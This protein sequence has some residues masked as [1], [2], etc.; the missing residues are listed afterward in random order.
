MV[1]NVLCRSNG[2]LVGLVWLGACESCPV[3]LAPGD[4]DD[5]TQPRNRKPPLS[6]FLAWSLN[7]LSRWNMTSPPGVPGVFDRSNVHFL[8]VKRDR[9]K[10]PY[11]HPSNICHGPLAETLPALRCGGC[12][13]S[14]V[15]A[16]SRPCPGSVGLSGGFGDCPTTGGGPPA[17]TRPCRGNGC[18]G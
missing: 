1:L 17:P 15:P 11:L 2:C 10:A 13:S 5:A 12:H 4:Q 6:F 9:S 16:V 3:S 18:N 14:C 7:F 8:I